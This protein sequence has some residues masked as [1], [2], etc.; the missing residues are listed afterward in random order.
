MAKTQRPDRPPER[1]D[2]DRPEIGRRLE[3]ARNGRVH[4]GRRVVEVEDS[5]S[6]R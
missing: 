6:T 1:P 2:H 4:D 5:T 3:R